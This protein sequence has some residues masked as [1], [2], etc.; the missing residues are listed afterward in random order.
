MLIS[1]SGV[2][3]ITKSA[4]F[5]PASSCISRL[6]PLPTTPITSYLS[7]NSSTFSR[8]LSTITRLWPS[9]LTCSIIVLPI[10]PQPI[11]IIFI[12]YVLIPNNKT[13][14]RLEFYYKNI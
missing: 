2:T 9:L 11:T 8:L 5:T 1:S 13:L 12:N 10:F 7:I 14:E 4:D 6:A 3:A